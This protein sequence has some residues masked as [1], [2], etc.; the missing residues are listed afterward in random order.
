MENPTREPVMKL[1]VR[2][3]QGDITTHEGTAHRGMSIT[4]KN[5]PLSR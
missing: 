4:N 2:A 5:N 3:N 1:P